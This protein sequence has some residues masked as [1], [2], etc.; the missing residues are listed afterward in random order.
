MTAA[1]PTAV[2]ADAAAVIGRGWFVRPG[3]GSDGR[4]VVAERSDE[5]QGTHL[6]FASAG[7]E[8]QVRSLVAKTHPRSRSV[9]VSR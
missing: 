4:V 7:D 2:L 9:G 6:L 5:G 3:R 1:D 8:E